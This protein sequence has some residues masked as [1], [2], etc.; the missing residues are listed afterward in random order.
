MFMYVHARARGSCDE[1]SLDAH[2]NIFKQNIITL[3]QTGFV[4]VF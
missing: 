1:E 4:N 2:A 3:I